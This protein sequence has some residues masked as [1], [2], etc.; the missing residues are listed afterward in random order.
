MHWREKKLVFS[1]TPFFLLPNYSG[2]EELS[3]GSEAGGILMRDFSMFCK[4]HQAMMAPVFAVQNQL[5]RM[6]LGTASWERISRRRV[7]VHKGFIVPLSELML[8]VKHWSILHMLTFLFYLKK[9]TPTFIWTTPTFIMYNHMLFI[10]HHSTRTVSCSVV[11]WMT[12]RCW[13]WVVSSTR[14]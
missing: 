5:K 9:A 13:A 8:L 7:E 2:L 14:C 12:L 1:Y 11:C 4:T 10:I 6:T 3:K